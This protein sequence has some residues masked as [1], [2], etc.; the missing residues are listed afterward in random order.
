[1]NKSNQTP[2]YNRIVYL[3]IIFFV[4]GILLIGMFNYDYVMLLVL[5][6]IYPYLKLTGRLWLFVA[7]GVAIFLSAIWGYIA[8]DHYEYSLSGLKIGIL[9]LY[10]VFFWT[11]G[12]FIVKLIYSGILPL[13]KDKKLLFKM[14]IFS[15]IFWVGLIV[16]EFVV[17]H[18][19]K[20]KN[21]ATSG[22]SGLPFIDAI[23]AP[24]WMQ[25]TYFMMGPVYFIFIE[26]T[27]WKILK[28][29]YLRKKW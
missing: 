15:S 28:L 19:F 12:L 25:I 5:L 16:A 26:I 27:E 10:P 13:F 18:I 22:N 14:L 4:V 8:V 29:N 6:I 20:V 2:G 11:Y 23:H 9:N 7:L 24:V 21:L 3:D 17:Y 1:M